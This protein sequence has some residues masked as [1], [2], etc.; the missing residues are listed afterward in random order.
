MLKNPLETL[1]LS[2]IYD[3]PPEDILF[4]DFSL[5]GIKLDLPYTRI[6]FE[7][8]PKNRPYFK[9]SFQRNIKKYFFALPTNPNSSY[10]IKGGYLM[11]KEERIGKIKN[12][13]NDTCDTS[14]PRRGGTVLNLNPVSKS[15]CHGCKFCH[16]ILQK[17]KDREENLQSES[18]LKRFIKTWLKRYKVSDLSHLIQVAIVSGCFGNEQKVMEYLKMLR[19]ILNEYNFKGELF[20]YGS[21]ITTEKSLNEMKK[22]KPFALCLSWEVFKNR[23]YWTKDIKARITIKDAKR[24]LASAK[25]KGF[26]TN[27]SYMLGLESFE[28]IQKGFKELIPYVNSFPVINIF[29]V[30]RGQK[31]LRYPD[32]WDIDYYIKARKMIEKMFK[33]MDI[34]PRI[35]ENYRCLWYL[36]FAKETLNDIRIP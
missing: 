3:V 4:L 28:I 10:H 24:I 20:Y 8:I 19:N 9:T 25:E 27:F 34:K 22:L 13:A 32:A 30:H 6:R 36:N 29:Q 11:T 23:K 31:K 16:T 12:L 5:H 33:D 7:F 18:T 14:Y 2:K 35:W 26:R 17:A 21:E 15:L 1:T